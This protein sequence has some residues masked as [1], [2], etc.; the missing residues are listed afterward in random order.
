ML[1][2]VEQTGSTN[3]DLRELVLSN[4]SQPQV[5]FTDEQTAGRGRNKRSWTMRS[6]GGIM[7]SFFV[8]GKAL[9]RA[10]AINTAL[11]VA[12]TDAVRE[13]TEVPASLK[14]PND[15][16]VE[17]DG[18]PMR[19]LGGI[20]AEVV[21]DSAEML[22]VVAGLGLNV[23]WPTPADIADFPADL[24]RAASLDELAGRATNRESLAASIVANFDT[25]LGRLEGEGI[26][27]VHARYEQRCLTLGRR[28]KVALHGHNDEHDKDEHDNEEHDNDGNRSDGHSITGTAVA[29]DVSGALLVDVEGEMTLVS[30]GDVM[31]LRDAAS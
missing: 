7:V 14:W 8:P 6:G 11:G 25:E 9:D 19:K 29:L 17:T 5:L 28:V 22:G 4:A 23:S 1:R 13:I 15:V 20:L 18:A 2:W 31:H 21:A 24:A 26:G 27:A 12:V 16:V 30:A 10:H 3:A